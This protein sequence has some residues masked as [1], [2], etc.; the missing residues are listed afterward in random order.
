MKSNQGYYDNLLNT[1]PKNYKIPFEKKIS[2]DVERSFPKEKLDKIP[3]DATIKLKKILIAFSLRNTALGYCQGFNCILSKVLQITNFNEEESFWLFSSIIED[4]FPFDYFLS[5]AGVEV[6]CELCFEYISKRHP[7]LIQ[8]LEKKNAF[9]VLPSF[10]MKFFTSLFIS[11]VGDNIS[12]I[13]I[14]LF[15]FVKTNP[16][17]LLYNVMNSFICHFEKKIMKIK[18][19][20]EIMIIFNDLMS[21]DKKIQD[22]II[23]EIFFCTME[24]KKRI[25]LDDR[26]FENRR[27]EGIEKIIKAIKETKQKKKEELEKESKN[28]IDC[29]LLWPLCAKEYDFKWN[30]IPYVVYR[31]YDNDEKPKENYFFE[32]CGTSKMEENESVNQKDIFKSLLIERRN[33]FCQN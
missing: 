1:F 33:H 19:I 14:D 7:H 29:D 26:E 12:N 9:S 23:Q 31:K 22:E 17:F 13:I 32:V 16:V 20:E 15:L 28:D 18:G 5:L 21:E 2:I 30:Y 25:I 27:N 24:D 8:Y 10:I 6:D 11:G 4:Y 3:K